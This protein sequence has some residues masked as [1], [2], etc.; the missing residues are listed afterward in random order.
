MAGLRFLIVDGNPRERRDAHLK[1]YGAIPG[2]A[3]GGT[4]LALAPQG[5]AYDIC[6]P[7]DEGANLPQGA[8]IS[9]YD[10]VALTGSSLHLWQR[11]PASERQVTLA[12]EIFRSGT[13]FFGSCWGV[14]VA[15][16][17][18]GGDVR[19]NPKGREVGF[20][21]NIAPTE[22]GRGHPLLDGR[23]AAFDAPAIHLDVIAA[24]PPDCT[25]LA[26]NA[27]APVQ[28]AEMR[29]EGGVF[30]GV[31]YHPEFTLREVGTILHR[32]ADMTTA[33]GFSR[34]PEEARGYAA[35]LVA[36]DADRS[37]FDIAWRLGLDAEVL[38]DGRRLTELRN[39]IG[40]QV[41]PLAAARGRG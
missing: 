9:D 36:L 35:D 25:V 19:K 39:W 34:S 18:A 17:A 27:Y 10:G 1:D 30:W 3:Y 12:R 7:A 8:A 4:L 24:P 20:A 31:Q 11:E 33:E 40:R 2:D 23:P 21:R 41:K 28:A 38:D 22:A 6:F 16:A 15:A 14:Q 32:I 26:S 13:A 29:H 37:R 5:S